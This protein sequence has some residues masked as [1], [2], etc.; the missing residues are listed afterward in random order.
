MINF[1]PTWPV[2]ISL[3]LISFL[4]LL[5]VILSHGPWKVIQPGKRF[6]VAV[7]TTWVIWAVAITL[8]SA[9]VIDVV[10]GALL[11]AA[12]TLAMFTFWTLIAWGFTISMLLA[13]SRTSQP[14]SLEEWIMAYTNGKPLA[15]F[16]KDRISLL[17]KL[18]LA[19]HEGNELV[20][21]SY[22]GRRVACL[23][24]LFRVLFG[25]LK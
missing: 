17:V 23:T 8:G 3:L 24:N 12:A 5:L 14:I 19:K 9:P 15:A 21:T 16:S 11:L 20:I 1:V 6:F 22:W 7:L 10:T 4:P 2:A 13:L 18:G 25:V